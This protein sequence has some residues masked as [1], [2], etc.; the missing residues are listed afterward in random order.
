LSPSILDSVLSKLPK[1]TDPNVLI[2][3][4]TADDAVD[5]PVRQV[6]PGQ[7]SRDE[8]APQLLAV[9]DLDQDVQPERR[10]LPIRPRSSFRLSRI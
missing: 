10:G 5:P 3:F 6:R 1:Q 9:V 4:D 8:R 7:R 2:G